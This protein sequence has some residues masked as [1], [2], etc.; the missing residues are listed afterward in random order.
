MI[1]GIALKKER[2]EIKMGWTYHSHSTGTKSRP[3]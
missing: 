2:R 1:K 3:I